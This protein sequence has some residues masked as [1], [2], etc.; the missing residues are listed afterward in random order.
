MVFSK[1]GYWSGL[2]FP[3][4]VDYEI[5][6]VTHPSSVALHDMAHSFIEFGK[7]VN[8][9]ISLISFLWLHFSLS[10]LWWIRIRGLWKLPDGRDWLWGNQGLVLMGGARLSKSLMQFSVDG[11]N[12][13][14][15]D[16][17]CQCSW[18][19][20]RPLST[21]VSAGHSWILTGNSGSVCCGITAPFSW[22][23]CRQGFVCALQ[24]SVSQSCGSSVIKSHWPPKS[25]S[26]W[27]LSLFA[28]SPHWKIC[29]AS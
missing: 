27:V 3:S 19:H 26:L 24:E 20:N 22:S 28:R 12:C 13:C 18:P 4:L 23:W 17:S 9:V 21:H 6:T 14:S 8:H 16:C 10:A 7:A 29:C 2:P 25:N 11:Q 5:S 1:Q 15:Q